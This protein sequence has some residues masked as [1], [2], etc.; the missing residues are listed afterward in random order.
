[1]R[2]G[3]QFEAPRSGHGAPST[4]ESTDDAGVTGSG[5]RDGSVGTTDTDSGGDWPADGSSTYFGAIPIGTIP[6]GHS[7]DMLAV[8][9]TNLY[10]T[11]GDGAWVVSCPKNACTHL[12]VLAEAQDGP[13]GIA[14]DATNVYWTNF[15][16]GQVMKCP[17]AGCGGNPTA[18][19][20]GQNDPAFIAV[21]GTNVYW[22]NT[23]TTCTSPASWG[24]IQPC[25][26]PAMSGSGGQVVE[27]AIAGCGD[28]PTVLAADPN[29]PSGI[30]V[31]ATNVYWADFTSD[32]V[33]TCAIGGCNEQP[34]VLAT[35]QSAP[36][37]VAVDGANVYW[38]S[39]GADWD[40]VYGSD[41]P[42]LMA[43]AKGGCGNA[44]VTLSSGQPEGS[45]FGI[46]VDGTTVYWTPSGQ[47]MKVP[48]GGSDGGTVIELG[49]GPTFIAVDATNVYWGSDEFPFV[50]RTPK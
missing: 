39:W 26:A 20:T 14:V 29:D 37:A 24:G 27:C 11:D 31:D 13:Y 35:G 22:T 2:V 9:E 38:T 40:S 6:V 19:A 25:S 30:A 32:Q 47:V 1:L 49:Y 33:K 41:P 34:T 5:T 16:G 45:P 46:A 50:M 12:T 28:A 36:Y 43:C 8:D 48:V 10:W 42:R 44:P 3:E 17:I 4:S 7:V 18:I 21:D 15:N 23:G